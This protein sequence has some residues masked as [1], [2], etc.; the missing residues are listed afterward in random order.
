MLKIIPETTYIPN[1]S[2]QE[3]QTITNLQ[4]FLIA[5]PYK[6]T[7]INLYIHPDT[8]NANIN[9][10]LEALLHDDTEQTF[11]QLWLIKVINAH[12]VQEISEKA[13][14]LMSFK[15]QLIRNKAF[16]MV[17]YPHNFYNDCKLAFKAARPTLKQRFAI[18]TL[19]VVDRRQLA[20]DAQDKKIEEL[21]DEGNPLNYI[22][23][24]HSV[25]LDDMTAESS[26]FVSVMQ[27]RKVPTTALTQQEYDIAN[28]FIGFNLTNQNL[29]T[30]TDQIRSEPALAAIINDPSHYLAVKGL[31]KT[32]KTTLLVL[33]VL[34]AIQNNETVTITSFTYA[35]LARIRLMIQNLLNGNAPLR[36][37]GI[38]LRTVTSILYD[39]NPLET[40]ALFIDNAEDIP[41]Q[42][43]NKLLAGRFNSVFIAYNPTQQVIFNQ[44]RNAATNAAWPLNDN[45]IKDQFKIYTTTQMLSA[46]APSIKTIYR[47]FLEN[48]DQ[49]LKMA[50]SPVLSRHPSVFIY[51]R[52]DETNPILTPN[53]LSFIPKIINKN[54]Q[55]SENDN[56]RFVVNNSQSVTIVSP[57]FNPLV[58]I[59]M[60]L[61]E[62]EK[63]KKQGRSFL[64][65]QEIVSET[66]N[67]T[68]KFNLTRQN[69]F[70]ELNNFLFSQA[71]GTKS[72]VASTA[73][74]EEVRTYVNRLKTSKIKMEELNLHR[75]LPAM[76]NRILLT[77]LE[78]FKGL[79]SDV[80]V[81]ILPPEANFKIGN[82]T[83]I[84]SSAKKVLFIINRSKEFHQFIRKEQQMGRFQINNDFGLLMM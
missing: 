72:P 82:Y 18:N 80:L 84:L 15:N 5:A 66:G 36:N 43:L 19:L 1:L 39:S 7:D 8:I 9:M 61:D 48:Y 13:R 78:S 64:T 30:K 23:Y 27:L 41:E 31:A 46:S 24:A 55:M 28:Y 83:T 69:D 16:K 53:E 54:Y 74:L 33:R 47:D 44:N 63:D 6:N 32:G 49:K 42:D 71:Q 12:E 58:Q 38:S 35:N 73:D 3:R 60:L 20:E 70:E 14:R 40:T 25:W 68:Q 62:T 67:D 51:D 4:N 75:F 56:G 22:K 26:N 77:T 37:S 29:M 34:R 65:Y 57:L 76:T 59:S 21:N 17:E 45:A 52:V 79:Q 81:A 10:V 11:H 50:P 2:L